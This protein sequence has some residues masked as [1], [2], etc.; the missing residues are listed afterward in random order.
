[1]RRLHRGGEGQYLVNGAHV[2]RTD[3]VELLADVGLGSAMGS[4]VSQGRVEAILASKPEERRQLV[5]EAAGLGRFKRPPPRRAEARA[6]RD[7][8]RA[9]PRRRGGGR[10]A[11]PAAC[12]PGHGG[13]ARGEARRRDRVAARG[14]RH[15]R[16]G[17]ARRR[18]RDRATTP[19]RIRRGAGQG[20]GGAGGSAGRAGAGR[21][22]ARRRSRRTRRHRGHSLPAAQRGRAAGHPPGGGAGTARA[23][24]RGSAAPSTRD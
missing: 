24:A 6:R 21:G 17:D 14:H 8:G 3:V 22:S 7:P 1:M 20:G 5:E 23:A 13:R 18:D 19:R 11:A 16:P 15:A 12:A 4:I 10:E 9:R 2:R